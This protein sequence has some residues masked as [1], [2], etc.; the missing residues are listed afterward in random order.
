MPLSWLAPS[1]LDIWLL[2]LSAAAAYSEFIKGLLYN[3]GSNEINKGTSLCSKF[4]AILKP[5]WMWAAALLSGYVIFQMCYRS[6][7][8]KKIKQFT[9]WTANWP[10][11]LHR[12][13]H[14]NPSATSSWQYLINLNNAYMLKELSALCKFQNFY[15]FI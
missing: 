10:E 14:T 11:W 1:A 13:A 7:S 9:V 8:Y 6:K 3:R 4:F 15:N 5:V 12:D 2:F